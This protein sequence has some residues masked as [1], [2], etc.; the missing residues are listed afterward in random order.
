MT[1]KTLISTAPAVSDVG[2]FAPAAHAGVQ[3][4][5]VHHCQAIGSA[6]RWA[7]RAE[8]VGQ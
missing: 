5:R 1:R 7:G 8:L 6:S 3:C 2:S 4:G